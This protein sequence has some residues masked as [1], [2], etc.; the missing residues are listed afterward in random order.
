MDSTI[1]GVAWEFYEGLSKIRRDRERE[2]RI[3]V[4]LI[5]RLFIKS[6]KILL[7][8]ISIPPVQ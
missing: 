8:T 6:F 4:N 7:T 2:G 5:F 1:R 3:N